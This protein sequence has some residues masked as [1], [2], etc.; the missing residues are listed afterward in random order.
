MKLLV[1]FRLMELLIGMDGA[2]LERIFVPG[3]IF[4]SL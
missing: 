4:E 3:G 2:F 1:I